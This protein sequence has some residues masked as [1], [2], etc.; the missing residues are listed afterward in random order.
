MVRFLGIL[1][2]FRAQQVALEQL[3]PLGELTVR[4]TGR[5]E[6][7]VEVVDEYGFLPERD[8]METT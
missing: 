6:R 1:E 3:T 8:E 2:L 5:D 4:W 7:P